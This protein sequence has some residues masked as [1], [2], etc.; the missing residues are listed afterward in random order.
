MIPVRSRYSDSLH[1]FGISSPARLIAE[2]GSPLYVYNEDVLRARC[3]EMKNLVE[4]PGFT[5]C[6]STKANG[7]PHLLRVIREEGLSADAM[8]PG[9]VALLRQAGFDKN[10]ICYVCNNV[11]AG[12]LAIA[13][14]EAAHVSVDSLS[15]I[16]SFGRLY[17]GGAVMVR[18][19]PG[20]GA[21]HHQKVITAGKNTKFGVVPEDFP[22]MR[23]LLKQYS[24]TL[25]GL[26]QHVGSLF[27][28]AVPYQEAAQWLLETAVSFPGL[29]IID[30]G[31]GFGIPYRKYDGEKRLDLH[32]FSRS[33][34]ALLKD[35]S[36]R[37]GFCG[38]FVIEP[39][40]YVVAESGLLLG[41]AHAV[42]NNGPVRYV[43]TDMGFAV[44][45]RPMMYDSF[46]DV[47]IYPGANEAKGGHAE[48]PADTR[49]NARPECLQTIVGNICETGDVLAKDRMLP[50]IREGDIIG[51]LDAGAYGHAMSSNYTQRLRPAEVLIR[52]DGS[53][54]LIRRRDSIE[55]ILAVYPR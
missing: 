7:N 19:N 50:E 40:R 39:G 43:G 15:Q 26:N 31:G 55:D 17:P 8:S 14:K 38:S 21:G 4:L 34:T 11:A 10:S 32:A 25:V 22:R 30:F 37:T 35:W 2:Y 42:K 52:N 33:F 27:M 13:A 45:A 1:F 24:L 49:T 46:H 54:R 23:A 44:L 12:E 47:E 3:R 5:A 51:M 28:D 6:F 29:G 36:A 53:S 16:E 41:T 20:I 18:V 48:I 9:E